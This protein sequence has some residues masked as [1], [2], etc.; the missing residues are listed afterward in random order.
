MHRHNVFFNLKPEADVDATIASLRELA[1][2]PTVTQMI[3]EKN[4]LPAREGRTYYAWALQGDFADEHAR[5]A[6]EKDEKHVEI[7]RGAFLPN[8][9]DFV[10]VD[11]NY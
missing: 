11:I 7:V 9:A 2:L 10:A 6:Y 3:V 5:E 8:V 4:I 1:S